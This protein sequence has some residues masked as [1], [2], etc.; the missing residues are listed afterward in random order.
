MTFLDIKNCFFRLHLYANR[1]LMN[2]QTTLLPREASMS[3]GMDSKKDGKKK[4]Q[5]TAAEKRA[6]KRAKKGQQTDI[7]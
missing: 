4:P 1:R 6:E 3:K 7:V 5:K 2:R